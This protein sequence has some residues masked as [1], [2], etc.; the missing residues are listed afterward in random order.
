MVFCKNAKREEKSPA[1]LQLKQRHLFYLIIWNTWLFA[2]TIEHDTVL[3]IEKLVK[4][5]YIFTRKAKSI[6]YLNMFFCPV[7][8]KTWNWSGKAYALVEVFLWHLSAFI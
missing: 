6:S 1:D 8:S 5:L 2:V 7:K 3:R 4:F